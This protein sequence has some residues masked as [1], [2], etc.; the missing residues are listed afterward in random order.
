MWE[1]YSP[2]VSWSTVRMLLSLAVQLNLKTRACDINNAFLCSPMEEG[3]N[4]YVEMPRG[5]EQE[6]KVYKLKKSL[7]GLRTSSADFFSF[8]SK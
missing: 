6:G 1:T 5:Y 4:V 3:Q 2:V 8:L 7:Y